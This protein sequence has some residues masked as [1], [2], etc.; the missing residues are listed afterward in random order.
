MRPLAAALLVLCCWSAAAQLQEVP[1]L[2]EKGDAAGAIAQLEAARQAGPLAPEAL[3]LL[4]A[5][6]LEQNR[7]ADAYALFAPLTKDATDPALL[8]HA[9]RAAIATGKAKEGEG[10][11]A[12]S[13][14][15]SPVSPAARLLGLRRGRRGEDFEAYRLLRPWA[16]QSPTDVEVLLPA[17]YLALKF[18]RAPEA[19]TFLSALPQEQ[20]RVRLLWGRLLLQNGDANGALA[21][22][23]PLRGL[24]LPGELARDRAAILAEAHLAAGRTVE[25]KAALEGV[26]PNDRALALL[27]ARTREGAEAEKVL[28]PFA[29]EVLAKPAD[30]WTFEEAETAASVAA[31]Y[32]RHADAAKKLAFLQ[33]SL[34]IDPWQKER[35]LELSAALAAAGQKDRADAAAREAKLIDEETDALRR[36]NLD[37]GAAD[38]TTRVLHQVQRWL[39]RGDASRAL[40]LAA[41][42]AALVPTDLRPRFLEVQALLRLQRFDEAARAADRTL[43]V[44]PENGD[45]MYQKGIVQMATRKLKEA[46]QTLRRA[47]E[48]APDHTAAMNDLA[49]LLLEQKRNAEARELLERALILQPDDPAARANLERAKQ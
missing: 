31:E 7:A 15:L 40:K 46:E 49:V 28:R 43:A 37:P 44:A 12:R 47:L 38:A 14:E 23:E 33:R 27:I 29:E 19:E 2:L 10:L 34:E 48:L 13:V 35:W 32:A 30:T 6:Y 18:R 9:G 25:A 22:V 5:L 26:T 24:A 4:G 17:A 21:M 20:P 39:L 1:A 36:F 45:A 3:T 11:L 41:R 16:L 8:Y 42:E